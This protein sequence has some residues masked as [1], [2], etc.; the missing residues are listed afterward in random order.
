MS[1]EKACSVTDG[2]GGK[3][4]GFKALDGIRERFYGRFI[5]KDPGLVFDDNFCPFKAFSSFSQR[6]DWTPRRHRFNGHD[7]EIFLS[8]EEKRARLSVVILNPQSA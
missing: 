5:K 1:I 6:N 8:R 3:T 7:A 4:H 2:L